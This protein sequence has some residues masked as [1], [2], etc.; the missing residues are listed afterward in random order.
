MK[1]TQHLLL[2]ICLLMIIALRAAAFSHQDST[3]TVSFRDSLISNK[4]N[5]ILYNNIFVNNTS[6]DTIV[7]NGFVSL[8]KGWKSLG[9]NLDNISI[10]IPPASIR[11][12][13]VNIMRQLNVAALWQKV[14]FS[15]WEPNKGDTQKYFYNISVEA[16]NRFRTDQLTQ[17][18]TLMEK[19]EVMHLGVHL[20]NTGNVADT[21]TLQWKNYSL[22]ID[23]G[24]KIFL[25]PGKDTVYYYPL[26][27]NNTQWN[28]LYKETIR[29]YI[30]SSNDNAYLEY[31]INRPQSSLKQ[32]ESPY[33]NIPVT[34]EGGAMILGNYKTYNFGAR[35]QLHF[36]EHLFSFTYKSKQFGN[37]PNTLQRN[38]LMAGY[39]Y[40]NWHAQLGQTSITDNFLAIG[41]G[42]K[43]TYRESD[44][45][46]YSLGVVIHNPT[47]SVFQS[48]EI[49]AKAKYGV[50]KFVVTNAIEAN[51]D[52][53]N[54]VDAIVVNNNVQVIKR[55]DMQLSANIGG[56]V[57]NNKNTNVVDGDINLG[58]DFYYNLHKWAFS[59]YIDFHGKNFPGY[60]KG[61]D[62]QNHSIVYAI[63]KGYVG[64][65][66]S[67]NE[68]RKNFL[69]D[70]LFNT[71]ILSYNTQKYGFTGGYNNGR[72]S[73][74]AGAGIFKQKGYSNMYNTNHYYYS[75]FNFE[76]KLDKDG[77]SKINL[78]SQ[79]TYS[80]SISSLVTS[81]MAS[82][83]Y[84]FFGVTGSYVRTPTY[85]ADANGN[86]VAKYSE[87]LNG[88]PYVSFAFFRK[89]LTGT[90]K[91][92]FFKT[93]RDNYTR[94]GVDANIGYNTLRTGTFLQLGAYMPIK[95]NGN[96]QGLP[97][98]QSR[99][100]YVTLS[101]NLKIPVIT[102]RKYYDLKV[103]V[104]YDANSNN[105][106]DKDEK[107]LG[108]VN[109]G[110]NDEIMMTDENGVVDYENIQEGNYK[111]D[112]ANSKMDDLVPVD[113]LIQSITIK[114]NTTY[115]V[116][117][118]KGRAINGN[119]KVISDNY[120]N[121]KYGANM[122][123]V[124]AEDTSGHKY[125]TFTDENGNFN[126]F[127]SEGIYTVSI[128]EASFADTDFKPAK[129]SYTIDLY[130]HDNSYV[131]F[132]IKQKKRKIRFLNQ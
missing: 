120:S 73:I 116:P 96:I 25:S 46:E 18:I 9:G 62:M 57:E 119:I 51:S 91:Y 110:I 115:Q 84:K 99:Y 107:S 79:N 111:L 78:I 83:N 36:G 59:S 1:K 77:S 129:V 71:D 121:Y 94:T 108:A 41:N 24:Q 117:F 88:G 123:E 87:T 8:P 13:P 19:P 55:D 39:D 75:D 105:I 32:N 50:D 6:N 89:T 35:G 76:R 66:Y 106:R 114:N 22:K 104:Y 10:Q 61:L 100:G 2:F 113:G 70:T 63:G 40:R 131:V 44:K 53:I 14:N 27:L 43:I 128:N 30:T 85:E 38:Y 5:K 11:N 56:G 26:K 34:I 97:L 125:K 122:I 126:L 101:Q 49:A 90:V 130:S 112:L 7:V 86:T 33:N 124:T 47:M 31:N 52:K 80:N 65:L 93:V 58:Y 3:F 81:N 20:K 132:E 69:R 48:D 92:M 82:A 15:F 118:K 127:V 4:S 67:L 16:E 74:M 23:I 12:I 60:K 68:I 109:M 17:D 21:Y 29:L 64:V 72:I 95:D 45:K 37:I 28:K 42:A 54:N 102:H 103:I 98:N